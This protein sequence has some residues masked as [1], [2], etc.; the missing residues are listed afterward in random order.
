[1]SE[2]RA[3]PGFIQFFMTSNKA[4]YLFRSGNLISRCGFSDNLPV[5]F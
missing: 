2:A 1:M 3:N 4:S 5:D